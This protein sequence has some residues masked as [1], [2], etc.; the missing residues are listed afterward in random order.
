[1]RYISLTKSHFILVAFFLFFSSSS[2]ATLKVQNENFW[3]EWNKL[4]YYFDNEFKIN[5]KYFLLSYND[6]S[7]NKELLKYLEYINQK[8]EICKF[9]ARY[10]LLKK[11]NIIDIELEKCSSLVEYKKKA[12]VDSFKY[13]YATESLS[14]VTG[15]LGHGFL[16]GQSKREDGSL[17]QH[18]YSFFTDLSS[19]NQLTLALDAFVFGLDGIFSLRPY[20]Q[21]LNKYLN[22]EG[23]DVWELELDFSII[24]VDYLH[25]L[26]WELRESYPTYYFQNFNCATI[27]LY[28]LSNIRPE[29][30]DH[31]SLF[32]TPVDIYKSLIKISAVNEMLVHTNNTSV[33]T[34]PHKELHD[35]IISTDFSQKNLILSYTPTSHLLRTIKNPITPSTQLVIGKISLDLT[36]IKLR[37]FDL[38][39]L[40]GLNNKGLLGGKSVE[41]FWDNSL[42]KSS[43][44]LKYNTGK[45]FEYNGFNFSIL[46]G[47]I[48]KQNGGFL[49]FSTKL[50]F[51]K[52]FHE[53]IKFVALL[54]KDFSKDYNN[55]DLISFNFSGKMYG[56]HVLGFNVKKTNYDLNYGLYF[57]YH[58]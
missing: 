18:S 38:Y 7:P 43:W 44:F 26:L 9:P 51:S 6:P 50:V 12:K 19:A 36:D 20:T 55:Q 53:D 41:I 37:R 1:M 3:E 4:I 24:E 14:S 2:F 29:L 16:M 35:S 57:D 54:E 47:F 30:L 11:Y 10:S 42:F 46:P 39:S 23:R 17:L 13:I 5:N 40:T 48:F 56:K 49:S 15:M 21:D 22:I 33:Q 34:R 52:H 45:N 25:D 28:L 27:T 8:K 58:F 31:E 32:V